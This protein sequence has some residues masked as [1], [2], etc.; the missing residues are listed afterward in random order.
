MSRTKSFE[1]MK[2]ILAAEKVISFKGYSK[3]YGESV[4]FG[5]HRMVLGV[6]TLYGLRHDYSLSYAPLRHRGG[7]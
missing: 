4:F 2:K 5:L 7:A 3:S 6:L 1:I